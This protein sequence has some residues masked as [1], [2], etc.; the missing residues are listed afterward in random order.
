MLSSQRF[1]VAVVGAGIGGLAAAALLARAGRSVILVDRSS[2]AGGACQSLVHDGW[3]F[4]VGATFLSGFGPGGPLATLCRRL[5][6]TL[7]VKECD[8]VFQVALPRHR[9]SFW[10]EQNTWWREVRREFPGDDAGWHALWAELN[11]LAVQR[12]RI[13][14]ELP[15]LPPE[16][17]GARLRVWRVLKSRLF[18]PLSFKGGAALKRALDTPFR[19]AMLRHGLGG[20]S[21]RVLEAALWF[22]LVRDPDECSTLEAAVALLQTRHGVVAVPGGVSG[23]VDAL[24]ESFHRDGGQLRLET[25]ATRFLQEGGR[26]VGVKTGGG[27]TIRAGWVVANVPPGDLAGTL[28]PPSRG[29]LRRRPTPSGPWHPTLIAQ[30]AVLALPDGAV[31]SELSGHCLVVPD[32]R[33]PAREENLVVVRLAPTWDQGQGPGGSRRFTVGRFVAPRPQDEDDSL[34]SDLLEALDQIVP[35]VS[36]AMV[37]HRALTPFALGEMWGRPAAAVR[38]AVE[39]PEWLGCRGFPHRLG[40]PGLLAVGEWTYPGRL[41]SQVVEGAM[42]VAD[43]IAGAG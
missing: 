28:L 23:L 26:I 41:I 8:P 31:P 43:L 20:E 4:E 21:Q 11:D 2:R 36:E 3:R 27:E 6:I 37:S 7:S 33:R 5:G 40:W 13:L 1:D 10:G 12:E 24:V 9:L 25:P 14:Q 29:W 32:P 35:G 17:W 34:L 15:P 22:L 18:S 16:G 19:A 42:R 38:Y 39:S 30:A